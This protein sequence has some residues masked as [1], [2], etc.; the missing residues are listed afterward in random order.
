MGLDIIVK[1]PIYRKY[2]YVFDEPHPVPL[3]KKLGE[4]QTQNI[5]MFKTTFLQKVPF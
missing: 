3:W 5:F 1:H 2:L 4:T